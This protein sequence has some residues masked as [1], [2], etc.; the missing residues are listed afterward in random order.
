[1]GVAVEGGGQAAEQ[2]LFH[3]A[4]GAAGGQTGAVGDTE[5]VGI[6]GD[7]GEAAGDVEHHVGGLPPHPGQRFEGGAVAGH[8]APVLAHEDL[9]PR[10]AIASGVGAAAKSAG[11]T[12]LTLTSVAWAE[13]R[14]A[15]SRVKGSR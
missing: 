3:L 14:T 4:R 6:D 13:R 8:F 1:M 10:A 7:G 12:L 2:G 11:V 5:D 15:T 9:A